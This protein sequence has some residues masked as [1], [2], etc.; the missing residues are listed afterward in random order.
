MGALFAARFLDLLGL[1]VGREAQLQLL[2]LLALQAFEVSEGAGKSL[3]HLGREV[4]LQGDHVA[5][6][7]GDRFR[8]IA[9]Q[10]GGVDALIRVG[11]GAGLQP[12]AGDKIRE[13]FEGP[14]PTERHGDLPLDEQ[15]LSLP[16]W[17]EAHEDEGLFALAQLRALDHRRPVPPEGRKHAVR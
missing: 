17:D 13:G 7:G 9:L 6:H 10:A 15:R 4:G 14:S 12:G 2:D 3:R 1:L 11:E 16:I 5:P 8:E